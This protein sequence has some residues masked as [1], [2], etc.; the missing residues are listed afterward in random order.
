MRLILCFA[1]ILALLGSNNVVTGE[2]DT[3]TTVQTRSD[4]GTT[5]DVDAMLTQ[6]TE[7]GT[8]SGGCSSCAQIA[9]ETALS[10]KF[11]NVCMRTVTVGP[12]SIPIDRFNS[13][14]LRFIA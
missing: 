10:T 12:N 1:A 5:L 9:E 3:A 7:A 2:N 11:T 8:T 4:T 13:S 14:F 6:T